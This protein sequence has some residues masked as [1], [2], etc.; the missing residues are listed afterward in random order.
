MAAAVMSDGALR[1][2]CSADSMRDLSVPNLVASDSKKA[3]RGPMV[4]SL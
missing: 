4:S 1:H 2:A 3:I